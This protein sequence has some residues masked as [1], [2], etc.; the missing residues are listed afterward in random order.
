LWKL[1]RE[2]VSKSLD[3]WYN[4][5]SMSRILSKS[6]PQVMRC[7]QSICE[8]AIVLT[9]LSASTYSLPNRELVPIR[10]LLLDSP[11]SLH[12]SFFGTPETNLPIL[13]HKTFL[14]DVW[15]LQPV[16]SMTLLINAESSASSLLKSLRD[17]I[18]PSRIRRSRHIV[19]GLQG[20]CALPTLQY[21]FL[22]HS[23]TKLS[24]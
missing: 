1:N 22:A 5:N 18:K 17:T 21:P 13:S 14:R 6:T 23:A 8:C 20:I 12:N 16:S 2:C 11:L 4:A 10:K 15:V 19:A 9:L 7:A 3:T 24:Y